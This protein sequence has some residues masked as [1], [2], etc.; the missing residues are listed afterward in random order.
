MKSR[1]L[2]LL[3]VSD[4][5]GLLRSASKFLE[6]FEYDVRQARRPDQ[7]AA[8]AAEGPVDFLLVDDR[9]GDDACRLCR[10][11]RKAWPENYTYAMLISDAQDVTELVDAL[12]SGYDDF[13]AR[14]LIYGEL[15]A[16]IRAGLR[17][18]TQELRAMELAGEC[19]LTELPN[20][21]AL[22]QRLSEALRQPAS[23]G[24]WLALLEIDHFRRCERQQGRMSAQAR[25][26]EIAQLL[27]AQIGDE[28]F[29]AAL[30][31]GRF[32]LHLPPSDSQFAS[33]RVEE[34]LK[35]LAE[36][37]FGEGG[38]AERFTASAGLSVVEPRF[39]V[40]TILDHCDQAL[41]LARISGGD[42]VLDFP[43][44]ERELDAW[45]EQAAEGR[46][47]ASTRARDVMQASP[48]LLRP[49]HSL[50]QAQAAFEFTR[51]A[52]LPVV[53]SAG[54]LAGALFASK[55]T[56]SRS[57]SARV[58]SGPAKTVKQVMTTSVAKFDHLTPLSEMLEFFTES[59]QE[60]AVVVQDEQPLG[61]VGCQSLAALNERLHDALFSA[62][63]DNASGSERLI[64]ADPCVA[65]A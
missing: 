38:A 19:P 57:Q 30:P 36:S 22:Q 6:V 59:G 42:Q 63:P 62:T 50:D 10:T 25:L 45:A 27:A 29:L 13:L 1:N 60:L 2:S 65:E 21:D 24:G 52:A 33:Q 44:F 49:D 7:V 14:P 56:S 40:A 17:V 8:A 16:R 23:K 3:L 35:Q 54:K 32:A 34:L 43:E 9:L 58:R 64:V 46:L 5:Q 12:Q 15:L 51:L 37:E 26:R 55:A 61:L 20:R 39:G 48:I 28:E 18:I 41:K 4:D 11:V 53:D 31:E 47:F